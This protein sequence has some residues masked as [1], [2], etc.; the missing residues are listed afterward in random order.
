MTWH[1]VVEHNGYRSSSQRSPCPRMPCVA[2]PSLTHQSKRLL[3]LRRDEILRSS[4]S[5][6]RVFHRLEIYPHSTVFVAS[7]PSCTFSCGQPFILPST[8]TNQPPLSPSVCK[9]VSLTHP[10]HSDTHVI[11]TS[12]CSFCFRARYNT[13]IRLL[14]SSLTPED[15]LAIRKWE[16]GGKRTMYK[17]SSGGSLG[18]Q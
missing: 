14:T 9:A 1:P 17:I 10:H 15:M 2:A 3:S 5:L 12:P 16:N 11:L 13:S 7:M 8:T 4:S 6:H 18:M